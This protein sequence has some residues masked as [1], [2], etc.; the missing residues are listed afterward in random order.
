MHAFSFFAAS[1]RRRWRR[2]GARALAIL[3]GK[4]GS[5]AHSHVFWLGLAGLAV[6]AAQRDAAGWYVAPSIALF[7]GLSIIVLFDI[8]YLIIPDGPLLFLFMTGFVTTLL[9]AP[10]ALWS[11]LVCAFGAWAALRLLALAYQRWRG[12]A[13][14]GAAD[15]K[16]FAVAGL[17]LGFR[18]LPGC[19]LVSALSGL[20]S[21]A[22]FTRE[23]QLNG[24]DQPIPFAPHLALGLWL[25]WTFGPFEGG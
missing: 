3:R 14:L 1:S 15:P 4:E 7:F 2:L 9:G 12:L 19:L 16:L 10:D 17:W 21:A 23:R 6:L 13:G 24:G 5:R 25:A 22:I 8:E 11:R 18:A 20:L